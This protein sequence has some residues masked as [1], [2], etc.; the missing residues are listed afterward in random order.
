MAG[1]KDPVEA[2]NKARET[3]E[4][5][6]GVKTVDLNSLNLGDLKAV[7]RQQAI[8]SHPF[9]GY[10]MEDIQIGTA[11]DPKTKKEAPVKVKKTFL[12]F[13]APQRAGRIVQD[14]S[15]RGVSIINTRTKEERRVNLETFH[16]RFIR[17][18]DLGGGEANTEV[19]F[20]RKVTLGD[21]SVLYA[22]IVPDHTVRAQLVFKKNLKTGQ[23]EA[24]QDYLLADGGQISRLRKLF[25]WIYSNK[26]NAAER[27]AQ[28]FDAEP[29]SAGE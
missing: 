27:S 1:M 24:D 5:E 3:Q 20:D 2:A 4:L 7:T 12:V 18:F 11:I 8:A 28:E 9:D 17:N 6:S 21:N 14:K 16:S 22:A 13:L 26:I 10:P 15:G 19:V 29:A 23:T 25:D